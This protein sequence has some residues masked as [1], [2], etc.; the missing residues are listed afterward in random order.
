[1]LHNSAKSQNSILYSKKSYTNNNNTRMNDNSILE[2]ASFVRRTPPEVIQMQLLRNDILL[3]A[4]NGRG[5]LFIQESVKMKFIFRFREYIQSKGYAIS[6]AY[7]DHDSPF[8]N[9]YIDTKLPFATRMYD[10]LF[11]SWGAM[12]VIDEEREDENDKDE[13][14]DKDKDNNK[15]E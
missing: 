2:S 10:G 3:A 8:K 13:N 11:I 14:K 4:S 1:M 9:T 12:Y 15:E 7:Y 5:R 6:Y